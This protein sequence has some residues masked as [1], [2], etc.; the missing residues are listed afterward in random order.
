MDGLNVVKN[1]LSKMIE[2]IRKDTGEKLLILITRKGY[3]LYRSMKNDPNYNIIFREVDE[4]NIY[5]DRY[6]SKNIDLDFINGKNVYIFDDA[7]INGVN[8]LR[9]FFELYKLKAKIVKC[10]TIALTTEYPNQFTEQIEDEYKKIFEEREKKNKELL[11]QFSNFEDFKNAFYQS[12]NWE[13]RYSPENMSRFFI[14]EMRYFQE[15]LAPLVMDLPLLQN[16]KESVN[17][18]DTINTD[19]ENAKIRIK[20]SKFNQL[21][22]GNYEWDYITNEYKIRDLSNEGELFRIGCDF[23]QYNGKMCWDRL[24]ELFLDFVVKVKYKIIESNLEDPE[25]ELVFTPFALINSWNLETVELCFRVLFQETDYGKAVL[26]VLNNG[27][28]GVD[29]QEQVYNNMYRGIIYYMSCY[30]GLKFCE[31]V[32]GTIHKKIQLFPDALSEN[33]EKIFYKDIN[34][35]FRNF[36]EI[37][38]ANQLLQLKGHMAVEGKIIQTDNIIKGDTNEDIYLRL[39]QWILES[40]WKSEIVYIEDIIQSLESEIEFNS[41]AKCKQIITAVIIT[42]LEATII[43]NKIKIDLENRIAHRGIRYG[44]MLD[45][46]LLQGSEYIYVYIYAFYL[47]MRGL[48]KLKKDDKETKY[49]EYYEKFIDLLKKY[50]EEKQEIGRIISSSA[51]EFLSYYYRELEKRPR[52]LEAQI[53]KKRYLMSRYDGQKNTALHTNE[54]FRWVESIV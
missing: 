16:V 40:K 53:F 49:C 43:G 41:A 23:F 52:D 29:K 5:T 15:R 2:D 17:L 12:L 24:S 31:Y 7:I 45:M 34:K 1:G 9:T 18:E 50:L 47:K 46:L 54:V 51:F 44:E 26:D 42:M 8:L 21:K 13:I 28:K 6:M 37:R 14:A 32:D 22:Q 30:V 11:N 25:L 10:Y 38:F 35:I 39:Y 19:L 48:N 33:S 27:D 4:G 20:Q 36:D 3:W